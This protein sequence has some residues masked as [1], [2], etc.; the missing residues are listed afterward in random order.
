MLSFAF[1]SCI[2]RSKQTHKALEKSRSVFLQKATLLAYTGN[3]TISVSRPVKGKVLYA[4]EFIVA[5]FRKLSNDGCITY[6]KLL[7]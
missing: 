3:V 4:T 6:L 5:I 1:P 2:S 7:I